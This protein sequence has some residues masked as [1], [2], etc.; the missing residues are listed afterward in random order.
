MR[1]AVGDT[2]TRQRTIATAHGR[3][4]RFVAELEDGNRK[5]S[6]MPRHLALLPLEIREEPAADHANAAE[7][8]RDSIARHS[9]CLAGLTIETPDADI[10][11]YKLDVCYRLGATRLKCAVDD[12]K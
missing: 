4:Y 6:A 11:G 8:V 3:G 2:R 1:R 12:F 10:H 9:R 5:R 7:Q